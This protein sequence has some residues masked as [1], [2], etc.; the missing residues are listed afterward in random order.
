MNL[1]KTSL[2]LLGNVSSAYSGSFKTSSPEIEAFRKEIKNIDY[3]SPR[4]DRENLRNDCNNVA[5]DYKR[6]F[7]K[8]KK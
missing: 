4:E 7:D 6:A 8:Y 1:L 5:K 2:I 3:P